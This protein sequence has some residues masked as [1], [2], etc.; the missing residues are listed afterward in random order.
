MSEDQSDEKA[1]EI[2]GREFYIPADRSIANDLWIEAETRRAGLDSL[3]L[4]EGE[5]GR[6]FASRVVATAVDGGRIFPLLGGLL[7]PL[8][9]SSSDWTPAIAAE[10][11]AH[12]MRITD[13]EEKAAIRTLAAGW[14]AEFF[15]SGLAASTTSPTSWA[16]AK[17][18]KSVEEP[19]RSPES[20][21]SSAVH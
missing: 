14:I 18:S 6:A 20:P 17:S 9:L 19:S 16:A 2:G 12:L 4:Q 13:R 1:I 7:H 21:A 11:G 3:H 5:D 15:I 10:T 8:G